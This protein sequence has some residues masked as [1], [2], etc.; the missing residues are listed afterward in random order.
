MYGVQHHLLA[1]DVG[2][3]SRGPD[4]VVVRGGKRRH[5]F[6]PRQRL[7]RGAREE[8]HT[9]YPARARDFRPHRASRR[10]AA[11]AHV[12]ISRSSVVAPVP[13]GAP[14][15]TYSTMR[16]GDAPAEGEPEAVTS[17]HRSVLSRRSSA[18]M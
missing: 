7:A 2:S 8:P 9:E 1:K 18:D 5:E 12:T 13:E 15:V 11:T 17:A 4:Q 16:A 10:D 14:R 6:R 3:A